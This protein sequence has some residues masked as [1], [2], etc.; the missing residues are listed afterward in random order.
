MLLIP[1]IHYIMKGF[2]NCKNA[3]EK[4]GI[5]PVNCNLAHI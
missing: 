1:D 2:N 3:T 4:T 5:T